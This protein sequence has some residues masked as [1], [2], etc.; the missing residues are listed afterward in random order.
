[1]KICLV[2]IVKNEGKIIKRMLESC[3]FII[4]MICITDTGSTDSTKLIIEEFA[5]IYDIPCKIFDDQFENFGKSRTISYQNALKT[6]PNCD[7]FLLSD[8]DFV[9]N[10][11]QFDK[12]QLTEDQYLV[13]NKTKIKYDFWNIRLLKN[14]FEYICIG[15]THEFWMKK[16][17]NKHEYLNNNK[18][19]TLEIIDYNDGGCKKN[20]YK[21][22]EKLLLDEIKT[23]SNDKSLFYKNIYYLGQTYSCLNEYEK[24][25]HYSRF[26]QADPDSSAGRW[27]AG[28]AL[29]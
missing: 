13:I 25:N 6:Y 19:T 5:L 14:N 11:K 9:W 29:Y 1:M 12:N 24:S 15:A 27:R 7:Y 8:A 10:D 2:S 20:K 22:D 17:N 16:V 4:D 3:L 21:R 18:L 28:S 23:L 26:G